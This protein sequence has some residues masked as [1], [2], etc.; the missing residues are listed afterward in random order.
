RSFSLEQQY[1]MSIGPL[2]VEASKK[3][4]WMVPPGWSPMRALVV[5]A[6]M[7]VA[8]HAQEPV[9]LPGGPPVDMD[10]LAYDPGSRRLF[11]PAGS[12]GKVDVLDTASGKLT[13][14]D[15]WP[16]AHAGS[17]VQG[18]SAATVGAGYLYVGNRADSSICA[19][20]LASLARKGC[21]TM[22]SA[23]DG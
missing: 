22:P 10:Y 15:G 5:L 4:C 8:A 13:S 2:A 23:P 6:S 7:A 1:P 19:V 14:I 16:T 21:A 17:R 3:G 12:T 9:A 20:E 18:P 11:V